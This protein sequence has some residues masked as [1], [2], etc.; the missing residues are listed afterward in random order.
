MVM[1]LTYNFKLVNLHWKVRIFDTFLC[2]FQGL[3]YVL[4]IMEL[5]VSYFYET[6]YHQGQDMVS[7]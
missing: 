6:W 4:P 3:K 1:F 2:S 7:G 5:Y